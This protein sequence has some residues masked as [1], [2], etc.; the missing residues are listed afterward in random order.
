MGEVGCTCREGDSQLLSSLAVAF[1]VVVGLLA[2]GALLLLW[3]AR[4]LWRRRVAEVAEG[5]GDEG[6]LH[7]MAGIEETGRRA[8]LP[9]PYSPCKPPSP[10]PY[11][12]P[13]PSYLQLLADL[14]QQLEQQGPGAVH[15]VHLLQEDPAALTRDR[16]AL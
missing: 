16:A 12:P 2:A 10:P 15:L 7:R 14:Q 4:R 6:L 11:S 9:P 1:I 13:A 8:S 3:L 5:A